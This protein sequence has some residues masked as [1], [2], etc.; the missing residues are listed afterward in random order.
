MF[1][2]NPQ[3]LRPFDVLLVRFPNDSTS[4]SIREA[5]KSEFSHAAVYLGN[6]SFIE[7]V[8]PVVLL[9][10]AQ[11]YYFPTLDDVRVIRLK[12]AYQSSFNAQAAENTLRSLAYCNYSKPLLGRMHRQGIAEEVKQR[13]LSEHKWTGGVVCSTLV[14]LPYY[15]GGIDISQKKEPFYVHFGDIEQ[16]VFFED[17]TTLVFS[18]V[19]QPAGASDYFACAETG[20]IQEAQ[21]QAVGQL[22]KLVARILQELRRDRKLY[23]T[24]MRIE[25]EDLNFTTWEDIVPLIMRWFLTEKGQQIDEQVY[26]ELVTSGFTTLWFE[27]VHS[28]RRL[29]FPFRYFIESL[30]QGPQY[31]VP[32]AQYQAS[33]DALAIELE[34]NEAAEK[35]SFA[36]FSQAPAK[37]L[38]ALLDMYRSYS[39]LLRSSVTQYDGIINEI[40]R[41]QQALGSW[42]SF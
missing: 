12:S 14:A 6:H 38:H 18:Q 25:N 15:A 39:D 21:S 32:V 13:F 16:N 20:S 29:F 27:E 9:F 3:E 1:V 34:R 17:V 35:A 42:P 4:A 30:A 37:T 36:N 24:I 31:F 23:D 28:H 41:L 22:N 11:R 5:C 33:R 19:V 10:S 7:G 2:L 26:E 8:E 40:S